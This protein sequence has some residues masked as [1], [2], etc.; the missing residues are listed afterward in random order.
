VAP[1]KRLDADDDP[2]YQPEFQEV[3]TLV[4]K[5][6]RKTTA[7]QQVK[8]RIIKLLNTGFHS[9]SNEHEAKNAMKLAQRLMR[10]HNLSQALLLKE[11]NAKNEKED[12]E[13]LKGGMVKVDLVN[14]NTGKPAPLARWLGDLTAAISD[15]FGV[16]SYNEVWRGKR[17]RVT[18]Y[19]IYTNAQLAGYAYRVSAERIAQ[20]TAD[21][22]PQKTWRKISTKSS[23]LSYALGMVAGIQREVDASLRRE[24]EQRERKLERARKAISK[25]EAYEESDDEMDNDDTGFVMSVD[26]DEA[27]AVD[28]SNPKNESG[29]SVSPS[30]KPKAESH[31]TP[32]SG[33]ELQRRAE[34]IKQESQSAL[35]LFDHSKKVAEK[36]LEEEGIKLNNGR[37]RKAIQFDIAAHRQGVEDSKEI[38]INQRAIRHEVKVKKEK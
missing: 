2:T 20:M 3:S 25:G 28:S 24:K 38:D 30:P 27:E 8:D 34:E 31:R 5:S 6:G 19:G 7:D 4:D 17:C 13:V 37:Q 23:R 14:R 22:Q 36:V 10:K 9:E 11:R 32:I 1:G 16:D 21:Y 12:G 15:N 35:A 33:E 18:F 26:M 29:A